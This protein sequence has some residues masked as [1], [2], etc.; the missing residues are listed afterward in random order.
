MKH[1]SKGI[2]DRT[3]DRFDRT[4]DAEFW[5][6]RY[7]EACEQRDDAEYR[8]KELAGQVHEWALS[9]FGASEALIALYRRAGRMGE[10]RP[11]RPSGDGV[12]YYVRQP[13]GQ[14]K[15]GYSSSFLSRM[16]ALYVQR[17]DV[18]AV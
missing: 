3:A 11:E 18:L 12:V 2:Q 6:A 10:R 15:I 4:N 9:E 17:K 13:R 8:L 7:E 1:G 14:V 16:Q 5:R